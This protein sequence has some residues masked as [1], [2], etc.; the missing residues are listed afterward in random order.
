MRQGAGLVFAT[1]S[2]TCSRAARGR[3]FPKL[4][5][6]HAGG[7]RTAAN[8]GTYAR[9]Y[10]AAGWPAMW[11]A[12]SAPAA[13]GLSGG[14]P[15]SGGGQGINAFA[16]GMRAANPKAT[17]RVLW[18]NT[19]FD[20][21]REREAAQALVDQGVD[22]LTHHSG[23]TAVAQ[24]AQANFAS[25]G[26][27]VISYPSDMRAQAPDAQ[28]A[29]IVHRWGGYYTQ[30]AERVLAGTWKAE[31]VWGGIASGMVD[32]AAIDPSLP[33][34]VRAAV[35]SHRGAIVEGRFR[36]FSGRLVDTRGTVRLASGALDDA[37]IKTMDWLVEGVAGHLPAR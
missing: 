5:F 13:R 21:S 18:L 37:R 32:I 9:Y 14:L 11:P 26:V 3:D 27:R 10:E 22:V 20:P 25:R 12:A 36:P 29:A 2:A 34:E 7:Y 16:L 33:P 28:A 4:K 8:L 30:V 1:T 24:A 23:S 35:A 19:W 17:V 6:E 31:A 15:G